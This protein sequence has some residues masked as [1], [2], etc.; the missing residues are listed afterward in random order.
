M[1]KRTRRI[2]K[3][4]KTIK[5]TLPFKLKKSSK[6]TS[7]E[8]AI[9]SNNTFEK[10]LNELIAKSNIL[11]NVLSVYNDTQI[12]DFFYQEVINDD[13]K[14]YIYNFFYNRLL[15]KMLAYA[16]I[17][18][19]KGKSFL[20]NDNLFTK[21]ANLFS[22]LA[23]FIPAPIVNVGVASGIRFGLGRASD[24]RKI[25]KTQSKLDHVTTDPNFIKLL[26]VLLTT[27][28]VAKLNGDVEPTEHTFLTRE[29]DRLL[30]L[31][32]Q[33][34]RE[35]PDPKD[36]INFWA[37]LIL[38]LSIKPS[39]PAPIY[40]FH[41]MISRL[42]TS[43]HDALHA[44]TTKHVHRQP[45]LPLS[46]KQ[47]MVVLSCQSSPEKGI[48]FISSGSLFTTERHNNEISD[49]NENFSSFSFSH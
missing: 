39:H 32:K 25:K 27:A 29:F 49:E 46:T 45:K 24:R 9:H 16:M 6:K 28:C 4:K 10:Q 21:V 40:H 41:P 47:A 8:M 35:F 12:T 1:P 23:Y 5:K 44:P 2:L 31:F 14:K 15:G 17:C 42:F 19:D 34:A 36:L 11:A 30:I 33:E 13:T 7:T 43:K 26:S 38:K 3:N 18:A 48:R 20:F 37:R 22:Y